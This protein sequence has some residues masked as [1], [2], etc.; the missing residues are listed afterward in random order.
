MFLQLESIALKEI[1]P[2]YQA[3]FIHTANMTLAFW[4]VKAGS[5]LPMHHHVHEQTSQVIEGDFQL[6]ID[7]ERRVLTPGIIAVIPSNVTHWGIA[8][9]DCKLLDIFSPAREDYK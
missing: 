6:T 9:T 8:L 1:A 2:G 4:E 5:I 3:R 7:G